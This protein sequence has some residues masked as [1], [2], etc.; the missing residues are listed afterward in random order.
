M[1]LRSV[2][3]GSVHAILDYLD[4]MRTGATVRLE[5]MVDESGMSNLSKT[6]TQPF[7]V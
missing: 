1:N 7:A 6:N 5:Y 3:P 2:E 4:A